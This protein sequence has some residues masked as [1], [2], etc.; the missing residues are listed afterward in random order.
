M[1][2]IELSKIVLE[3]KRQTFLDFWVVSIMV[4]FDFLNFWFVMIF[5]FGVLKSLEN[6]FEKKD[7][8]EFYNI[9]L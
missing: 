6:F 8:G 2:E 3:K 5:F 4:W 1:S 7:L 9:L